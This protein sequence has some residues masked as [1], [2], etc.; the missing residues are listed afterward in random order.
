MLTR[1]TYVKATILLKSLMKIEIYQSLN[2]LIL[3]EEICNQFVTFNHLELQVKRPT[4][5]A[6]SYLIFSYNLHILLWHHLNCA[7]L[8]RVA[9]LSIK[10]EK[11]FH[12]S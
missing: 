7:P 10:S 3:S 11:V 5:S 6:I 4:E 8:E 12:L 9:L 1:K 2:A